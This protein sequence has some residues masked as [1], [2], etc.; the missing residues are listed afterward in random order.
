MT[1]PAG[2]PPTL[3]DYRIAA[4]IA[5]GPLMTEAARCAREMGVLA[6]L[7]A[8]GP[9]TPA[10]LTERAKVS[11]YAARV[12]L[13]ACAQAAGLEV[14]GHRKLGPFHTLLVLRPA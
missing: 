3:N 8:H 7:K 6:A 14:E 11:L 2:A 1:T 5:W 4:R 13:E 9:L 10:A 12:L